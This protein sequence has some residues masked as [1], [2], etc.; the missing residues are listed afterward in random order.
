MGLN[1]DLKKLAN[2]YDNISYWYI[3]TKLLYSKYLQL[4][5]Y[6]LRI[7]LEANIN[8][9]DD[10]NVFTYALKNDKHLTWFY[11]QLLKSDEIIKQVK[12]DNLIEIFKEFKA[13]ANFEINLNEEYVLDLS[14]NFI[15]YDKNFIKRKVKRIWVSG[16][17]TFIDFERIDEE[18]P[19]YPLIKDTIAEYYWPDVSIIINFLDNIVHIYTKNSKTLER[20]IKKLHNL[21]KKLWIY[22]LAYKLGNCY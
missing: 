14:N 15:V 9:E 22:E 19:T 4:A 10:G 12:D 7:I 6:L 5:C 1:N 8:N 2:M 16:E 11:N 20:A 3:H 13:I 21:R 18:I 17:H